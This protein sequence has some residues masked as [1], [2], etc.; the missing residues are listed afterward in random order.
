MERLKDLQNKQTSSKINW[1][2][3]KDLY[4]IL[5]VYHYQNNETIKSVEIKEIE[6]ISVTDRED[7]VTIYYHYYPGKNGTRTHP[8]GITKRDFT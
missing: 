2:N 1:R 3:L 8:Y 5:N 4:N 6:R 7:H